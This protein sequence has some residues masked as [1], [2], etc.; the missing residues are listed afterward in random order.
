MIP[1]FAGITLLT[2]FLFNIFGGDPALRFAGKH[3]TPEMIQNIR[4]E[5][6]LDK[7]V[8]EQY[9]NFLKQIITLD[10]G[11]SWASQQQIS[12][13]LGDGV[14]ASLCLA[15][16]IYIFSVIFSVGLAL[17]AIFY[18]GKFID[19]LTMVSS[20]G[21]MSVSSLVYII[22]F[23]YL[24]SFKLGLF[25]ISGWDP[26]WV[27]RWSY[28]ILPWIIMFILNLGPSVLVYRSVI[29]DEAYQ[30]YVRTARAKGLSSFM[31]F[32][33]HI[34][35]NAMIPIVTIIVIELPFV[36]TG[37]F[38]VEHFFSIPGLGGLMIKAFQDSDFPLI[39]AMTVIISILYMFLNLLADVLY[40]WFDPR[41]KL[42]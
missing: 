39:K 28:L 29:A 36:L 6:G 33:K 27:D 35:K 37:T 14:G 4:V 30:D 41:I 26:S 10:F 16:P 13:I 12:T 38:L 18:R 17:L 3:A 34:L 5:L 20:L 40:A 42:S 31:V 9:F 19:K 21:L 11:R 7:S 32:T 8:V 25:P 2:F 22:L 23:Q 24:L 15:V 1:V